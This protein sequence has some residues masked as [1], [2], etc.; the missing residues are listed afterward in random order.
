MKF[1]TATILLAALGASSVVHASIRS[2]AGS[3]L[4]RSSLHQRSLH[5]WAARNDA[6]DSSSSSGSMQDNS[7]TATAGATDAPP[8]PTN[9]EEFRTNMPLAENATSMED[10]MAVSSSS[11]KAISK[12]WSGAFQTAT[13]VTEVHA[14]VNF[15]HVSIP[16]NGRSDTEYGGSAWVGIDGAS[17]QTTILQTGIDW[18][19]RGGRPRYTAWFEWLPHYSTEFTGM[20]VHPG[21][22]IT[23]KVA[24]DSGSNGTAGTA[25]IANETT[26]Q[27]VMHHFAGPE[28]GLCETNA[29]WIVE[30]FL[31]GEGLVPFAW[32]EDV[33]FRNASYTHAAAAAGPAAA[34][35][36]DGLTGST[37]IELVQ[38]GE[39][40]S[41]CRIVDDRT[42]T[43]SHP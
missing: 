36:E 32:F 31:S 3:G 37:M 20:D 13:Q 11:G 43:C 34:A 7:T 39:S 30:D 33:T 40:K 15:P 10:T 24:V 23:M 9:P 16:K 42:M 8:P 18:I 4:H 5:R 26:G 1:P 27:K 12:N 35:R 17:C 6:G 2:G 28:V 14:T 21:D 38:D 41:V 22:N 19:I 29:E 25:W